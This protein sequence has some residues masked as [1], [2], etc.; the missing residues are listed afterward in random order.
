MLKLKNKPNVQPICENKSSKDILGYFV[1]RVY[2]NK[3]EMK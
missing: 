1:R 2:D 3:L